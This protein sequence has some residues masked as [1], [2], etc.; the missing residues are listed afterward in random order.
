MRFWVGCRGIPGVRCLGRN[1]RRA[2][3]LCYLAALH[4]LEMR[5]K[6]DV[7]QAVVIQD[8]LSSRKFV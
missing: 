7:Y 5:N 8:L 1:G 2:F 4:W 3:D 6:Y